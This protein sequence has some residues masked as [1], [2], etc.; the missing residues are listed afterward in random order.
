M[1][2]WLQ[3]L[4]RIQYRLGDYK[5]STSTRLD[6]IAMDETPVWCDMV[7]ETTIDAT[8]KKSITLKSTSHEK[9][10]VLVCLALKAEGTKLKP[11]VVFKEAKQEVAAINKNSNIEKLLHHQH[12]DG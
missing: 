5:K 9:A 4:Y 7:S 6:I 1:T 11:M 10:R 8:G 2:E 12:K 3:N